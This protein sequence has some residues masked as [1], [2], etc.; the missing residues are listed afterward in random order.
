MNASASRRL[1]PGRRRRPRHRLADDLA[2]APH[3]HL[4]DEHGGV[5]FDRIRRIRGETIAR[6][7]PPRVTPTHA[8]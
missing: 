7:M 6:N 4:R 5:Y 3:L 1:M 2:G 8:R